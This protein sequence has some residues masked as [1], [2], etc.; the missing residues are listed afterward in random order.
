MH[1]D[2]IY[3]VFSLLVTP[4]KARVG[5]HAGPTNTPLHLL[6]FTVTAFKVLRNEAA[7]A[8][9]AAAVLDIIQSPV[10]KVLPK[11]LLNEVTNKSSTQHQYATQMVDEVRALLLC[12]K[13]TKKDQ[14]TRTSYYGMR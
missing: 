8:K 13:R 5:D 2:A 12:H 9:N 7:A 10:M 11:S 3:R 14:R 1:D 6:N 4:L